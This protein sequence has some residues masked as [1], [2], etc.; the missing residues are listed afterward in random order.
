MALADDLSVNP[1]CTKG[2]F[3]ELDY[4]NTANAVYTLKPFDHLHADGKLYKSIKKLYVDIGDLTE[5]EFAHECF[6]SWTHWKQVQNCSPLKEHIEEWREELEVK[7]R[8]E[9]LARIVLQSKGDKGFTA[10][11]YIAG[12]EYADKVAG[13]PSK[14][15]V[16]AAAAKSVR[17]NQAIQD[18]FNRIKS[19]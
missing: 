16:A 2:L 15:Q 3:L 10:A 17:I 4:T 19:H 18:N 6:C 13:R 12:K 14:K 7:M 9:S 11:K 5:W 1:D 8:S